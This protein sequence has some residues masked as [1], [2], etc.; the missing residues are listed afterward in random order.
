M[1]E[2]QRSSRRQ[3]AAG[4]VST[5]VR[6]YESGADYMESIGGVLWADA[7]LPP[8]WH[9]CEPQTRRWMSLSYTERCACGAIRDRA[10]GPWLD[11]N[12]TR[13]SRA[14]ERREARMPR[15]QVTCLGCGEQYEAAQGT[16]AARQ[17]ECGQCWA[18][19]FVRTGQP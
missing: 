9:R 16:P 10:R 4:A 1:G 8:R 5:W 11:R 6:T 17:R 14:K 7:S 15:E 13:K 12:Q 3:E 2:R 19:R 18:D